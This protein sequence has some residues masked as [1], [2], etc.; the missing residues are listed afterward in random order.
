[1][2]GCSILRFF[3]LF[4]YSLRD[5]AGESFFIFRKVI[6]RAVLKLQ[7]NISRFPAAASFN[8]DRK[9]DRL[10][11]AQGQQSLAAIRLFRGAYNVPLRL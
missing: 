11:L 7:V 1:M 4:P 3:T 8:P 10:T 5:F 6:V 9:R 2:F